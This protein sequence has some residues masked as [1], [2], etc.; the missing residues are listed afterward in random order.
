[1][2]IEHEEFQL[3]FYNAIA[4]K[5]GLEKLYLDLIQVNVDGIVAFAE[6]TSI[7]EGI[8]KIAEK[9]IDEKFNNENS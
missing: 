7:P 9:Y 1:M 3:Y 4:E 6:N 8:K 2:Q 5:Y